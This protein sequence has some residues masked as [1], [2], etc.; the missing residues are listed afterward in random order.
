MLN[1]GVYTID[2]E[3]NLADPNVALKTVRREVCL[4]QYKGLSKGDAGVLAE[5]SQ[6]RNLA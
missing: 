3:P 2:D 4:G 1:H 6:D 5:L